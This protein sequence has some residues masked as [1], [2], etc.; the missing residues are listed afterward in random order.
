MSLHRRDLLRTVPVLAASVPLAGCSLFGGQTYTLHS[1]PEDGAD[2]VELFEW[3][4]ASNAFH[5][6]REHVQALAD[7]LRETGTVES[8]EIP[9]VEERPTGE[10][11]YRP[12]YTRRAEDGRSDDG[13]ET[14][15]RVRVR[16]E[17]VTV[18][19]WTVW[20]EPLEEL[21]SGVEYT[22]T[23]REGHSELDAEIVDRTISRAISA[24]LG[25]REQAAQRAP[26]R[27]VVFFDPLDPDDSELVPEPPFEYALVEPEAHGAPDELPLRLHVQREAVETARYVHELDPIA[28]DR[29][30]FVAHLEDAHVEAHFGSDASEEVHELLATSTELTGHRED[31]PLSDAFETVLS[32]LDLESVTLPEGRE[33]ASWL[34]YYRREGVYYGAD[35]RISGMGPL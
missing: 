5:Y 16:E 19:R 22:T 34:R 33:V 26:R 8:I 25:D 13:Q 2:P 6:D 32:E 11:G 10:D 31:E 18:E 4:P 15:A 9:L 27:G 35:L 24:V 28:S 21:P 30:A 20:M 12:A 14:Y 3:R 7:R 17:P 23:P 1:R 29:D